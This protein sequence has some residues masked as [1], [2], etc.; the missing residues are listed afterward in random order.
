MVLDFEL[1]PLALP[2][3][4]QVGQ[5]VGRN[6]AQHVDFGEGFGRKVFFLAEIDRDVGLALQY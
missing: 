6:L 1:A 3:E 5:Q 4:Q 2:S